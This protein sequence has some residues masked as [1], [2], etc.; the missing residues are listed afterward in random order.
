MLVGG[1]RAME[2]KAV[3]DFLKDGRAALF[4]QEGFKKIIDLCLAAGEGIFVAHFIQFI[5]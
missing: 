1:I 4:V 5:L 2:A 3:T